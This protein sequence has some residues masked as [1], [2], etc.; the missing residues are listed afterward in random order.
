[1]RNSRKEKGKVKGDRAG[2]IKN[3]LLEKAT[4]L[5]REAISKKKML[6]YASQRLVVER[7]MEKKYTGQYYDILL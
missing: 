4:S 5:R 1:M 7:E 3:S 2:W 6:G